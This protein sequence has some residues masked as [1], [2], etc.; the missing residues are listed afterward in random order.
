[1]VQGITVATIHELQRT[2]TATIHEPTGAGQVTITAEATM[3]DI[4]VLI[5]DHA[6]GATGPVGTATAAGTATNRHYARPAKP[7]PEFGGAVLSDEG[8]ASLARRD[9]L[10]AVRLIFI[11]FELP[12]AKLGHFVSI[13]ANSGATPLTSM[14]FR[15]VVEKEHT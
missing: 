9:G 3:A 4:I 14:V 10:C 11:G 1:M 5:I 13:A 7:R 8:F 6:I 12:L 15:G 2:T